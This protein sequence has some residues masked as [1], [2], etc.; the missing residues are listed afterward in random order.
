VPHRANARLP[1]IKKVR[2][3][4][5]GVMSG[6]EPFC[7]LLSHL[8]CWGVLTYLLVLTSGSSENSN[9]VHPSTF[10]KAISKRKE[11]GASMCCL[12]GQSR[13]GNQQGRT[14]VQLNRAISLHI[15][16]AARHYHHG[17][18]IVK[19]KHLHFLIDLCFLVSR[20]I[21]DS[22]ELCLYLRTYESHLRRAPHIAS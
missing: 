7:T 10:R 3:P 8:G 19:S 20:P 12:G 11:E 16:S 5:R 2:F 14:G 9:T 21:A 4:V 6:W 17:Q 1:S 18:L 13:V 22:K 15:K